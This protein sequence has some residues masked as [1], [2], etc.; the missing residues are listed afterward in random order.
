[1]SI[2]LTQSVIR[3]NAVS[4]VGLKIPE[5]YHLKALQVE[6]SAHE[7]GVKRASTVIEHIEIIFL[8]LLFVVSF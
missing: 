2:Y 8:V 3:T 6:L 7:S 1:M 4:V 5:R